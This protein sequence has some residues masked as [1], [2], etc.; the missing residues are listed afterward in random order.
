MRQAVASKS[1]PIYAGFEVMQKHPASSKT[2]KSAGASAEIGRNPNIRFQFFDQD[3]NAAYQCA[4][5]WCITG[6]LAFAATAISILNDWSATL[7]K[8]S[9]LDAILCA[10]LGGFKMANA[11]ELLRHTASGWER[12]DAAR[13]GDLLTQVFYPVIANFAAFANGNWD[14]AA[15]KL[16]LAIAVYTDDRSMFD[17]AVTYYLHGCGDGRLEHYI[18]ATGQCQESGRDQQHT[19]LGIAH[20]GDACE[21]AWRQGLDLYGAVDNR[22][23]VGFEYTAKYGLGGDVPFTP[24]VD[25][26]GKYRHAVNS[27]R[28]A[29]RAVYEQIYNHYSRRRGIAAP[30]TEKAAEK[31]RPEGAPFQADAT[32]YGTLLY[33]RPERSASA[34]ASPT[35]L[36]VLYA[37][38]NA[39]GIMLDVVPL[40]SG[41]AVVLERAD[42]AQDRWA[43]LATGL[44]ARTYLDRTA[45]PGRLYSYRVT[46]PSRHSA[47]LPVVGMRGLPAGWHARNDGR[48]NASASFDGTAFILTA[49]GALP[50]DKGGAIFSIEHPAPPGATLTAKLNP[51][52]ASGFVGLGLVLRGASPAAEILLHISPKAGMPEHPAWSASLFERT[53]A[54]GMKLA[55]QAPLVSPTIENGRLADPL[56]MRLKTG[57]DETH[58][59]ISVNATDWTEIAK[60]PT[61]AGALTLGL[62][63]HS[64]IESV[65]TEV[66]FEEVTLVS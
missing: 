7:K 18:Y 29:L 28:S 2:Y 36:T 3:A 10:S 38:G 54:A 42:A 66:R 41:A 9:G 21:I 64:G 34:D 49:D 56:W 12:A 63:A 6:D 25:R 60:A 31:L 58:A 8:I 46:L 52:V 44:T 53:G 55:G 39:D 40:A 33:T 19:Q 65:T 48:L 20:M 59:S 37:Q 26:T 57:P 32:G 61:P 14:T 23:L 17:R 24:D 50:P 27:E 45:E 62:Y 15:I 43:P 1:Q 13:F 16:M 22:L 30:W 35:P 51:L 4:L 47:S 11:A 5:M